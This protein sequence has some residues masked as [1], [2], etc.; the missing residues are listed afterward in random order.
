MNEK[1]IQQ[2]LEIEKEAQK[3]QEKA[4]REAQEIPVKA[5]QKAQALISKAKEEAQEE[6]RN[7]VAKVK[8]KDETK[9]IMT[10]VEKKNSQLDALAKKNF[11]KAVAY[12]LDRVIGKA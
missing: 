2:V 3:F 7:I 5:E 6:A 4:Q 10:E 8:S 11:N 12:V 1:K 9:K